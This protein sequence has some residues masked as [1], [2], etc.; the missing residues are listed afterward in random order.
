[1]AA[2]ADEEQGT[3]DAKS[4]RPVDE[5]GGRPVVW[6]LHIV[7]PAANRPNAVHAYRPAS[8]VPGEACRFKLAFQ[9]RWH[10]TVFTNVDW[11][12][13]KREGI[14]DAKRERNKRS[15]ERDG[16]HGGPETARLIGRGA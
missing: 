13:H 12:V 11:V 5:I 10:S 15:G 7:R 1:M 8:E 4:Q 14:Q 6:V 16:G 2:T 9:R 3:A